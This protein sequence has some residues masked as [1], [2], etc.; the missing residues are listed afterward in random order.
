M[1][2]EHTT[3]VEREV[4]PRED[5]KIEVSVDG[6]KAI[7]RLYSYSKGLGW[8]VQKTIKINADLLDSVADQFA[9]ARGQI[10]REGDEILSADLLEF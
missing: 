8:Y 7:I 5:K 10:R 6:D 4:L 2:T 9:A 1:N 3:G